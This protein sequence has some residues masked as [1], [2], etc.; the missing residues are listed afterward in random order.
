M[1]L[2]T[3]EP[4]CR[5]VQ[6]QC[7]C[8]TEADYSEVHPLLSSAAAALRGQPVLLRYCADEVA[9]ARHS[10]VFQSFLMALTR[11]GPGG[12]PR[13]IEI[14]AHNPR[15]VPCRLDCAHS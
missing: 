3:T 15:C 8:L 4:T 7:Q 10:A 2:L 1:A 6:L 13:P 9:T 14:H 11:G 12:I 5:W